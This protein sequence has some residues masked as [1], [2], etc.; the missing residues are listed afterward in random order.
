M[1]KAFLLYFIFTACGQAVD[2]SQ[3]TAPE[4]PIAVSPPSDP[5]FEPV[6][7]TFLA[8]SDHYLGHVSYPHVDINFGD[9]SEDPHRIAYCQDS[10]IVIDEYYWNT[11]DY[12]VKE[13][14]L[15]HEFGHCLLNRPHKD[16]KRPDGT[17]ESLM[18]AHIVSG[19]AYLTH[20][21]SYRHELFME[22]L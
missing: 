14:L 20:L 21:E 5:I 2:S 3:V 6:L 9:T 10:K 1:K 11:H 12:Y 15:F 4:Q 18:S 16:S 7:E 13:S 17:P 19:A 8:L 22:T